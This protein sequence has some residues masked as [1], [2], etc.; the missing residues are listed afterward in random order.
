MKGDNIVHNKELLKE[1]VQFYKIMGDETRLS[2]LELLEKKELNVSE[3]AQNL[4]MTNSAISHQ[5]QLLRYHDLVKTRRN[6][7]EIYYALKDNHVMIILRYG[8]EHILEGKHI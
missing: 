7:K 4:N 3:I 6:G 5:L 1:L 8:I 2:I